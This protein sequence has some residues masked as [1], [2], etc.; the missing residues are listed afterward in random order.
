MAVPGE[1]LSVQVVSREPVALSGASGNPVEHVTLR[2]GR[3]LVCK[4]VSPAH[5]WI[6]RATGD[7]GRALRMWETGVF[8]RIPSA[9]DH[10]VIAVE[11]DGD[12][13]AVFMRD[14]SPALIQPGRRLDRGEVRRLLA[15]LAELHRAFAGV[16]CPGLCT[17]TDRYNLLSPAT[18]RREAGT[19]VGDTIGRCW[20]VFVDL[21]AP[22][23]SSA[24]VRLADAPAA[25]AAQLDACD[26][27]LVH[28]DVRVTNLGLAQD[29]VVLV[30]WGERT[31]VA[32]A[33]VDLASFL[34]F[35]ASR[36]EV[37][38]HDV[39]ADFRELEGSGFDDRAL[40]LALIGGLVQLAPNLVLDVVVH[41]GEQHLTAA[42]ADLAWWSSAVREA[43]DAVWAPT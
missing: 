8:D 32:P 40:Q 42:M 38:R 24:I 11:R 4:R 23:I 28:G 10:T 31:G 12:G 13:W 9:I 30:D 33:A 2:D 34:A 35:D 6:S 39:I 3:R 36:L 1:R 26:Q 20:E 25:L 19:P 27:T 43:F 7:D 29:R 37:S 21:A 17:S 15:A 16:A 41:G 5:D 14:V 22:D 18:A